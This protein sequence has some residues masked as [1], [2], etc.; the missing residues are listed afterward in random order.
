VNPRKPETNVRTRR[1]LEFVGVLALGFALMPAAHA[2]NYRFLRTS[3]LEKLT[4]QDIEIGTKATYEALE[5]GNGTDW[6]NPDTG[7]KGT[8]TIVETLDVDGR[9]GCRRTFL[10]VSA[11]G[12]EGSGTYTLCRTAAGAWNFY[13]PKPR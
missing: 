7:A 10:S 3:V 6:V 11:G 9:K 12:R 1:L 4:S 13:T 8:V 5:S 2:F